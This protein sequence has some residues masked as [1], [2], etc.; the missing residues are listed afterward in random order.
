M[1]RALT[2]RVNE[3]TGVMRGVGVIG[4]QKKRCRCVR[5][6]S[7]NSLPFTVSDRVLIG[8]FETCT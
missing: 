3:V 8:L 2:A 1:S 6:Q 7:Q 5:I 4:A